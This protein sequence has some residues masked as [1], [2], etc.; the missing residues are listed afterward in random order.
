MILYDM[1]VFL[2]IGGEADV[3]LLCIVGARCGGRCQTSNIA[4]CYILSTNS[5]LWG[6][7]RVGAHEFCD[8]TSLARGVKPGEGCAGKCKLDNSAEFLV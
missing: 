5:R 2:F 1:T 4:H 8:V 3:R 6:R 7:V